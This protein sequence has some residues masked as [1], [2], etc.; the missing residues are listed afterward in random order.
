MA[1]TKAILAKVS[2]ERNLQRMALPLRVVLDTNVL[3]AA[4]LSRNGASFALLQSLPDGRWQPCVSTPLLL[5]YEEQLKRLARTQGRTLTEVDEYLDYFAACSI[6][7][8]VF[9]LLRPLPGDP[10]DA[11]VLEA[12]IAARAEVIVTHNVADFR[13]AQRFGVEVLTPGAFLQRCRQF[14]WLNSP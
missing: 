6:R 10:D 12:A 9:F 11:F 5:E 7:R 14:K 8:P 4:A 1:Q 2:P 13:M 3:F